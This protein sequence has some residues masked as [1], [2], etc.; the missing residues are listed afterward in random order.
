ME[1]WEESGT[2]PRNTT[3]NYVREFLRIGSIWTYT[4]ESAVHWE[5]Q[6][7]GKEAEHRDLSSDSL[8]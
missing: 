3:W 5:M 6:V 8:L 2:V 4:S 1:M 7:E